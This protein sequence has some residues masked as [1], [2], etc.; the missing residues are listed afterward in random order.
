MQNAIE[1][2]KKILGEIEFTILDFNSKNSNI[3]SL[4]IKVRDFFDKEIEKRFK[5]G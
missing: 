4:L 1:L 3:E 5:E 2:L